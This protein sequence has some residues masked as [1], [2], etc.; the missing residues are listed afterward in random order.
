MTMTQEEKA[1]RYDEIIERLKDF[2]F[3]YRFSPFSDII[4]DKFPELKESEDDKNRFNNLCQLIDQSDENSATK[5]GFKKWLF[6]L[7]HLSDYKKKYEEA[8]LR[9][10]QR[11]EAGVIDECYADSIFSE[12]KEDK[13]MLD[14]AIYMMEQ[15]DM[16]QSWDDVYGWLKSLKTKN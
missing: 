15:L 3:E 13:N 4:S 2:Q 12:S 11:V 1:K 8:V 6:S 5:E 16:T 10:K 14:R 7:R 9:M